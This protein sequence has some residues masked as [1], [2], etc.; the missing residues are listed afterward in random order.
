MTKLRRYLTHHLTNSTLLAV[1]AAGAGA[2]AAVNGAVDVDALLAAPAAG[3]AVFG[4]YWLARAAAYQA[5]VAR[6]KPPTEA[7]VVDDLTD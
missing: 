6:R 3:G 5:V 7:E 2:V 1:L 4:T